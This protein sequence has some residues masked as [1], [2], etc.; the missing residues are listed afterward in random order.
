MP[1]KSLGRNARS[2]FERFSPV[3]VHLVDYSLFLC[4]LLP[5]KREANIRIPTGRAT[6]SLS[7][8]DIGERP[9]FVTSQ[10]TIPKKSKYLG[11][12]FPVALVP[13]LPVGTMGDAQV[14]LTVAD[15]PADSR[16]NFLA[17]IDLFGLRA[18]IEICYDRPC[19]KMLAYAAILWMPIRIVRP[20]QAH[21]GPVPVRVPQNQP[22]GPD[23]LIVGMGNDDKSRP[24]RVFP[25]GGVHPLYF[26]AHEAF[27]IGRTST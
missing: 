1:L 7:I 2:D 21:D 16:A 19:L 11:V 17:R 12:G 15:F 25:R 24:P 8:A 13:V 3:P 26:F 18:V 5:G 14:P 27:V 9:E 10:Y 22:P 4:Q 20:G 23:G 6:S